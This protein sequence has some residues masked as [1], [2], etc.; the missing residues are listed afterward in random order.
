MDDEQAYLESANAQ[1]RAALARV[2]VLAGRWQARLD[3]LCGKSHDTLVEE[4]TAMPELLLA[5]AEQRR[6]ADERDHEDIA[7]EYS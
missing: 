1:I 3:E 5:V 7:N 6:A 4:G 2:R